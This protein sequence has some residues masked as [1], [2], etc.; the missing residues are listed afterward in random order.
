MKDS[1]D[2]VVESGKE[3]KAAIVAKKE[4]KPFR[5]VS[6]A[7]QRTTGQISIPGY[8]VY[9]AI[10]DDPERPG[11]KD[12]LLE[13]GFVPVLRRE[14]YGEGCERPDEHH[15]VPKG[16]KNGMVIHGLAM[17]QPMEYHLEDTRAKEQRNKEQLESINPRVESGDR[18][19]GR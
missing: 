16:A 19:F 1:K 13:R 8:Y 4:I 15:I 3:S 2:S 6:L 5:R 7:E 18:L 9:T 11:R 14:V 10:I 12:Q 17:K